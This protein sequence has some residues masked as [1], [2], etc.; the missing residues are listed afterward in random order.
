MRPGAP[1]SARALAF[2]IAELLHVNA[3][4]GAMID[5]AAR[6]AA[7]LALRTDR[8]GAGGYGTSRI[9]AENDVRTRDG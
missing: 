8:K 7:D 2:R 6:L 3:T 1:E 5:G 9:R 4:Q